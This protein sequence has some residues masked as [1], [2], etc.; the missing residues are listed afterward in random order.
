M[1]A[2]E[3]KEEAQA[4]SWWLSPENSEARRELEQRNPPLGHW[5]AMIEKKVQQKLT[6][7]EAQEEEANVRA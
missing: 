5:L 4:I 3:R 7:I 1:N 6:E 2:E